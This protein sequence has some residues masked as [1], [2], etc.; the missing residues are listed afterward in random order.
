MS[1]TGDSLAPQSKDLEGQDP[2]TLL[3]F[4]WLQ[5]VTSEDLG[6]P[7]FAM[8]LLLDVLTCVTLLIM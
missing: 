8:K 1:H 6:S 5:S 7:V 4:E 3:C 2:S